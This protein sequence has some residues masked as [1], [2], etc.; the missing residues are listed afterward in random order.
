MEALRKVK[1]NK[2][3][4]WC[5]EYRTDS[6][7]LLRFQIMPVND[8]WIGVY[9][10]QTI[11]IF[12]FVWAFNEF[13]IL[14]LVFA[15]TES[16]Q[17]KWLQEWVPVRVRQHIICKDMQKFVVPIKL[18]QQIRLQGLYGSAHIPHL[19]K[20]MLVVA[21]FKFYLHICF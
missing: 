20:R 9:I 6:V 11:N 14:A 2:L 15:S 5:V 21:L 16:L 13:W 4:I 3:Y 12:K 10:L 19:C 17:F 8:L 1:P 18:F 7:P